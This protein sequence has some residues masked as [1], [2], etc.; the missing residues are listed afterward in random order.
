M[1]RTISFG[2]NYKNKIGTVTT[3]EYSA[4]RTCLCVV[5]N[6]VYNSVAK[7]D[8]LEINVDGTV[9]EVNCSHSNKFSYPLIL[10]SGQNITA[11]G[12]SSLTTVIPEFDVYGV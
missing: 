11:T 8:Y 4:K 3:G 12:T 2:F 1:G 7:A 9:F 10:K 5:K 6:T